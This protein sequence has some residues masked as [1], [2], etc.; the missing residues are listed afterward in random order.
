MM[1]TQRKS[2]KAILREKELWILVVIGILYFHR[3]LFGKETFYFRDLLLNIFPSK[4]FLV[5]LINSG[6]LP[7]WNPYLHGGRPYLGTI[8][9]FTLHPSNLLYFFL[10]LVRAF[11]LNIVLHLIA[12]AGSAY[13]FS[14]VIGL[15]P[16]SSFIT[17]I[18][19]GFCGSTLSIMI[20]FGVFLALPYLPILLL[21]WH[22]FLLETKRIWFV[23][24]I[25][26]GVVQVLAGTAEMNAISLLSLLAWSLVYP[27][28]HKSYFQK[29]ARWILL[30]IFIAGLASIQIFPTAELVLHSSRGSGVDYI[31]FSRLSLHPMRFPELFFPGFLGHLDTYPVEKYYWGLKLTDGH[32]PIINSIYFGITSLVLAFFGGLYRGDHNSLPFRTRVFL[33]SVFI[34]SLLLSTG[35]FLPF[36]HLLYQYVPLIT[37]FR[38]PLKFLFAGLFPMALLTGYA[39]EILFG[40]TKTSSHKEKKQRGFSFIVLGGWCISAIL[41]VITLM[42]L[43]S[44]NFAKSFQ[45]FFFKHSG[46]EIAQHGLSN[47]LLHTLAI[48]SVVM[49][50]YQYRQFKR[51]SWQHWVL[52]SILVVDLLSAGRRVN[53]YAPE[54]FLTVEPPGV[55]IIRQEIGEGRLFQKED[56]INYLM[57]K[58]PSNDVMWYYRWT[59]EVLSTSL[60]SLYRL[61]VIFHF[62]YERLASTHIMKLKAVI[63]TSPW[64][65]RLPLLSAAGVSVILTTEEVFA[66]GIRRITEI[67]NRSNLRV[68]LYRNEFAAKRVEFV[69]QWREAVSDPEALGI[70]LSPHYDPRKYVVLQKSESISLL[71]FLITEKGRDTLSVV[72]IGEIQQLEKVDV[73]SSECASLHIKTEKSD[74]LSSQFFVSTSCDGVLVFSEP[75]YPGWHVHIDGKPASIM[76]ANYA[77]SAVFLKAGEHQVKR[78]YRPTS[79]VL[80]AIS[81]AIF[82][83]GLLL[84]AYMSWWLDMRNRP[85]RPS[86][87]SQVSEYD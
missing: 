53:F 48:W 74:I 43:F 67:P 5:D 17:G 30:V 50:L 9:N 70:M 69:T 47:S 54:E 84:L 58:K 29:S 81:S 4:Q 86:K 33:F 28:S 8:T 57:L 51:G 7:L 16:I 49:I 12:C 19:Y 82:F 1:K 68:Y 55:R 15:T 11:N 41:L 40:I 38:S 22:L 23:M 27:Y 56:R 39:S 45:E 72:Q 10:P 85:E 83:C 73:P 60:G 3:P 59:L 20:M 34:F 36:F 63:D 37:L 14:R 65:Q 25:I 46:G 18:V 31:E 21:F 61:P 76:R 24:A 26:V 66:P 71:D 64:K 79:V 80:G 42:F 77:F 87:T 78:F 75:F 2:L 32:I 13:I 6:Q 52:A 44:D 35:R 62:N